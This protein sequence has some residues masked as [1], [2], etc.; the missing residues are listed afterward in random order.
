MRNSRPAGRARKT[1]QMNPYTKKL[2]LNRCSE[3]ELLALAGVGAELAAAIIAR[4]PYGSVLG[5]RSVPG[6]SAEL[7]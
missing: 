1:S 3:A 7:Y 2:D 4:R 5:M 6:M